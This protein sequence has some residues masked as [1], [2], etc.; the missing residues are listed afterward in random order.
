MRS[1][2]WFRRDLRLHDNTGLFHAL[3]GDTAIVPI[4]I[5]DTDILEQLKDKD[6]SR[7]TFIHRTLKGLDADLRKIGSSLQIYFGRPADVF[8]KL[9]KTGEYSKVFLNHD[10][11]PYAI[12]RDLEIQRIC[13]ASDVEF[14]SFKDQVI[15][16]KLE[17]CK[18]DSTPYIVYTPYKNKWRERFAKEKFKIFKSED[19][20]K[21]FAKVK[22]GPKFPSLSD[23]G[24]KESS[25]EVPE[26]SF[27]PKLLKDYAKN[28]NTPS[29][30]GT[31]HVGVHLRFGTVSVRECVKLAL[32]YSQT[33]L[34]E[35]IWREFFMQILFNFPNVVN[36]AAKAK[37]SKIEWENDKKK[38][39]RWCEGRT[40]FPIVDAGMRELN[41]TGFMHN[42]VRMIAASFLVK[43]LLIDWRWGEAYFAR[44]LLDY[45]LASNNGNWQWVAGTGSDAAPYFRVFN[46]DTQT[47]KFDPKL[48]YI[49]KWV[50]EFK[51]DD[52]IVPMV[53]LAESRKLAL[54]AYSKSFALTQ[55]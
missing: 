20:L 12:E 51:S 17:V 6:D 21:N 15:F 47:K 27:G 45:E 11:E 18:A 23:I 26:P 2:F 31:S 9:L 22:S 19:L 34:D 32:K 53:D 49:R 36:G 38:F 30:Q 44:K 25:I 8:S 4:F 16:E 42:R 1:I 33:W 41:A 7:V 43:N 5:F 13:S 24:F 28:R 46:P 54:K 39:A 48:E 40:G 52:Y 3:S 29:I 37:Y 35:L 55:S 50:P 10:Y 14:E